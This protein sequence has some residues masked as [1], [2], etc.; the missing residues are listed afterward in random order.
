MAQLIYGI[1]YDQYDQCT[2]KMSP[3][4]KGSL[5]GQCHEI[6]D[7]RFFHQNIRPGLRIKGLKPLGI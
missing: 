1:L 2:Y 3:L 5:K 4:Q 6:F 7:P